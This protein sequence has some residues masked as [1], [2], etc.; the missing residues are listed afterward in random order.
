MKKTAVLAIFMLFTSN[1]FAYD[2]FCQ[3]LLGNIGQSGDHF[4]VKI[5]KD[6][7]T[8]IPVK[9]L[10]EWGGTHSSYYLPTTLRHG[11]DGNMYSGYERQAKIGECNMIL[12][13]DRLYSSKSTGYIKFSCFGS[14]ENAFGYYTCSDFNND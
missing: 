8:I 5:V 1:S 13:D 6:S 11:K 9:G 10:K 3:Y 7:I 4:A 2:K 12:V 14:T